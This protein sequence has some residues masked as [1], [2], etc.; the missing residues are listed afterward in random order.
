[1][2]GTIS[3]PFNSPNVTPAWMT[4]LKPGCNS[5]YVSSYVF[6]KSNNTGTFSPRTDSLQGAATSLLSLFRNGHHPAVFS[7][8]PSFIFAAGMLF[9]VIPVLSSSPPSGI[10]LVQPDT[11]SLSLFVLWGKNDTPENPFAVAGNIPF[12][13]QVPP[14][15]QLPNSRAI[16]LHYLHLLPIIRTGT[17]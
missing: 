2:T 15:L 6:G 12:R 10:L 9:Q 16:R 3:F 7:F 5:A 14:A 4:F 8:H 11:A 17:K 1:M 13:G